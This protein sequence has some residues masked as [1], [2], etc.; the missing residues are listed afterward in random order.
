MNQIKLGESGERLHVDWSTNR[1]YVKSSR[2]EID[3]NAR[4]V[5]VVD[6]QRSVRRSVS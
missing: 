6:D 1:S 3:I 5:L 4:T 2:K